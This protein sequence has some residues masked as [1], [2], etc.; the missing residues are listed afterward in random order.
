LSSTG[1]CCISAFIQSLKWWPVRSGHFR[2]CT[3]HLATS[4]PGSPA[5]ALR[6]DLFETRGWRLPN[7][8]AQQRAAQSAAQQRKAQNAHA[9]PRALAESAAADSAPPA[10]CAAREASQP[11]QNRILGC[12]PSLVSDPGPAKRRQDSRDFGGRLRWK[13]VSP[14]C[15]HH[16]APF[17]RKGHITGPFQGCI[18][19]I[20][21]S[22]AAKHAW[23]KAFLQAR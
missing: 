6:C 14:R 8:L 3:G 2:P 16:L 7:F 12:P 13:P 10:P 9:P 21:G 5:G 18:T 1:Q 23:N 15:E 22:W 17:S 19:C 11:P 4:D 20:T